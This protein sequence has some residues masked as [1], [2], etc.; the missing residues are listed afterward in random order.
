[1]PLP[2]PL[3]SEPLPEVQN[4][5]DSGP[6]P[7]PV[8]A[9]AIRILFLDDDPGRAEVF[10]DENPEAVWVQTA[11]EC[12]A[13]LAEAWDEIHLDH[14]LGGEYFVDST[15]DDCGMAVVRWLTLEGR[16]HLRG[17]RF[18]VH[19][20]NRAGAMMMGVQL[21]MNGYS[22]E[23]RPFGV[24]VEEPEDEPETPAPD[25]ELLAPPPTL[26]DRVAGFLRKLFGNKEEDEAAAFELYGYSEY[27]LDGPPPDEKLPSES[28]DLSWTK[29]PAPET[30]LRGAIAATRANRRCP[31]PRDST[32]PGSTRRPLIPAAQLLRARRKLR[33]R[34]VT[35]RRGMSSAC[36]TRPR[37]PL[38][39]LTCP[40]YPG[41][42]GSEN[43]SC[44][45]G[46]R[47]ETVR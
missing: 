46:I 43:V 2:S 38:P 40:T 15:R 12:I 32:S 19:S 39:G 28:L 1:M 24:P 30:R 26:I 5:T 21:S 41:E 42:I 9:A 45:N 27:R 33:S 4:P 10:L 36:T 23:L 13:R 31:S 22:A 37:P 6:G 29:T 8:K 7:S 35:H 47:K 18:V 25:E 16:P 20:H 14:D 44:R 11:A 34:G 3:G 17:S